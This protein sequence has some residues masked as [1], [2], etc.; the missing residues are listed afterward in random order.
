MPRWGAPRPDYI[1]M[2]Y[3]GPRRPAGAGRHILYSAPRR[4]DGARRIGAGPRDV[5]GR[6]VHGWNGPIEQTQVHRELRAVMGGV[7][8][9]PPE[10]PYPRAFDIEE[11]DGR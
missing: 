8:H 5:G 11:R 4:V 1:T 9:T 6:P 3:I 10:H 2:R 7:Q